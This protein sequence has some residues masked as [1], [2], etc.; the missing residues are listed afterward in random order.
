MLEFIGAAYEQLRSD[1]ASAQTDHEFHLWT[2]EW[3]SEQQGRPYDHTCQLYNL[4][5]NSTSGQVGSSVIDRGHY[6]S[7]A[8]L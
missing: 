4:K 5:I 7:L 1:M 8:F 6:L 2:R 3:S